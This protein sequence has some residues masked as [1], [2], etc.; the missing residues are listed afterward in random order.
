MLIWGPLIRKEK[1][2]PILTKKK[3]MKIAVTGATSGIGKEKVKALAPKFEQIFLLVRDEAKARELIQSITSPPDKFTIIYCDLSDLK[4][5]SKAAATISQQT[6]DLEILINNSG[7]IFPQRKLTTDGHELTF[8]VNHLG[9]FLL[10]YLLLPLLTYG[11]GGRVINVSSEAHKGARVD[12]NDFEL[13]KRFSPFKA[14]AN[15]KLFNILFTKSLAEKYGHEHL[16]AY[17]LHP[18][19]VNTN[20]G[21][22]FSGGLKLLLSLAKPFMIGPKEG[23]KT[24]IF[25]AVNRSLPGKNGDYFKHSKVA[26]ISLNASSKP[27]R[28]LLWDYSLKEVQPFLEAPT[29]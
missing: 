20:F 14:Y 1:N 3:I 4:S 25:L 17:A 9:H 13:K 19:V 24:G 16:T 8:A 22:Q 23:A 21:Q 26:K 5:V 29:A 10:T 2:E 7:G 12:K 15:A 11:K 27:L 28:D 18:G 6:K